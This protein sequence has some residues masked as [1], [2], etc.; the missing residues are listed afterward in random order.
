MRAVLDVNVLISALLSPS[1]APA[2]ILAAWERGAFE[3]VASPALIAELE[4]TLSYP[5]LERLIA[6][7]GAEQFVAWLGAAAEVV[8]DPSEEPPE[9]SSDP[10]DDYLIALA[11]DQRVLLVSGD[12][13]LL[14]LADRV[15][16]LTP[17][18]FLELLAA[19]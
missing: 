11:A 14:D 19:D 4:R 9:R 18:G 8:P 1:G 17:A 3:L 13:H 12:Q 15:P 5:K 6:R 16:I 10:G 7:A 2:R